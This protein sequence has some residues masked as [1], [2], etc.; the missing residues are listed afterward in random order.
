MEVSTLTTPALSHWPYSGPVYT[1]CHSRDTLQVMEYYSFNKTLDSKTHNFMLHLRLLCDCGWNSP[2]SNSKADS[3][4]I[5]ID[6]SVSFITFIFLTPLCLH[7]PK[8]HLL[9]LTITNWN[10]YFLHF[11]HFPRLAAFHIKTQIIRKGSTL[12]RILFCRYFYTEYFTTIGKGRRA[13]QGQQ[14][15]DD[16]FLKS[17]M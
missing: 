15:S 2:S 6:T 12:N 8:L 16:L 14:L 5:L 4:G 7:S 10:F 9:S 17:K 11:I 13:Q 1:K 3:E